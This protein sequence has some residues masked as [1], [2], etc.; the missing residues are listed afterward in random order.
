MFSE[1]TDHVSL[2]GNPEL[3]LLGLV[4]CRGKAGEREIV[5]WGCF[6]EPGTPCF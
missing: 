2:F 3:G 4:D 6:E 5:L 1:V